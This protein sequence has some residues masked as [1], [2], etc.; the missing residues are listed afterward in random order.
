M[1]SWLADDPTVVYAILGA[2][3]LVVLALA[4][5]NRD[6]MIPLGSRRGRRREPR[7]INALS[8]GGIVITVVSALAGGVFLIDH[9]VVT[10]EEQIVEAVQE[11]ADRVTRRDTEGVFRH[12]SETFRSP[13]GHDKRAFKEFARRYID[14]GEVTNVRVWEFRFEGDNP[15][16][17][18]LAKVFFY[19]KADASSLGSRQGLFYLVEADF[20]LDPDG[21]WRL[22]WFQFRNPAAHGD[23]IPGPS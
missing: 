8:L 10:D 6:W 14:S 16:S 7:T 18:Q 23:I 22:K 12:V 11:M 9:L 2:L 5:M 3:A 21:K 15:R 4:W 13:Q 1:P 19:A 17:K 20:C